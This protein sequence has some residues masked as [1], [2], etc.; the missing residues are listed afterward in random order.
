MKA[1]CPKSPDHK[2][3]LTTAHIREGWEADP[4]GGASMTQEKAVLPTD[5]SQKMKFWRLGLGGLPQEYI[6]FHKTLAAVALEVLK[7]THRLVVHRRY[8][9]SDGWMDGMRVAHVI[10]E[11]PKGHLAKL[12]WN[13]GSQEWSV[14]HPHAGSSPLSLNLKKYQ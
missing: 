13:D 14:C 9:D 7:E 6:D 8:I 3:F 11:F 10:V 1:G 4:F 5:I 12:K 2:R